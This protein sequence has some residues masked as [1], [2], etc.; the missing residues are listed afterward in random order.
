MTTTV[1][2]EVTKAKRAPRRRTT[3]RVELVTYDGTLADAL[4]GMLKESSRMSWPSPRYRERP[5]QFFRD[6]LG[7]EPWSKQLEVIDA[8]KTHARVAVKSGHKVS[9]S[10][11]ASGIA[12]WFYSSFDDAR[13]VMTSTTSRQVDDILWREIRMMRA[14]S[15]VC[16]DCKAKNKTLSLEEQITV[17]C[18]HSGWVDGEIGELA[19]T[20]L[21]S[22]DFREIKG[23]TAREA[24]A[25]AGIS[26]KNLLYILDEASG[27]KPEIYEAIEG[28]RA[29]GARVILF[30]NPT[31]TSGEFYDAFNSK[32]R[33]YHTITISSEDTPNVVHG[34]DDPRAIP[35]LASRSWIA[36]KREE[37]GEDSPLYKV[38]VKGEFA[39][40][41]EGKIFSV[42]AIAEAE[43]R[44]HDQVGHG[45]LHIGLDPAG[46]GPLSDETVW[47]P[48]RGLKAYS[49]VALRNLTPQALL[50]HT[51][52][53]CREMRREREIPVVVL[54]AEGKIGSE[55]LGTFKAYLAGRDEPEFELVPIR[56]SDK[57][58][59]DAKVYDRQ[60]DCLAGNLV[61]WLLEGGAIPSDTKLSAELQVFE[62]IEQER[63][64]KV[65]ITPKKNVRK[66][67]GRSP[68][69][70][71][72]LTYACWEATVTRQD[73]G[74]DLRKST[75]E[76]PMPPGGG[77]DP[78][79][80]S[81]GIDPYGAI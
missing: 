10:H 76:M 5:E 56:A 38:R 28:N 63:T 42:H 54:D 81:A 74:K 66:E 80:S 35:G 16:V 15:G 70:Y 50:M 4:F 49:M 62:W 77:M 30:S 33:F 9:K 17:P 55:V 32:K 65:K 75:Y 72:A 61:T 73:D 59:R 40:L 48:R 71:D 52:G 29:G 18:P 8:V 58:H 64:G 14:R 44:W 6:I 53:I 41:E 24:E 22:V 31:R 78:Y 13:V 79:G 7:V 57:A 1:A 43:A 51:V 11:S 36:E 20:G 60:R 19:R 25:V 26:G 21:K 67:L 34:D 12:L 68:D 46:V 2:S 39:E 3:K 47:A 69:R 27:I 45:R 23:F 37:W